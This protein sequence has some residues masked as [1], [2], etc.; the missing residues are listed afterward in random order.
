M[1]KEYSVGFLLMKNSRVIARMYQKAL[2][3]SGLTTPQSGIILVL[4]EAGEL[5]QSKISE[6]LNLDKANASIMLKRMGE[7][8][9]VKS[10]T[11]AKDHRKVIFSLTPKGKKM[12]SAIAAADREIT[13]E[14]VDAIGPELAEKA[15]KILQKMHEAKHLR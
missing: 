13:E 4:N 15:Q 8:G 14:I 7:D 10:R 1:S 5:C 9:M 2:M 3:T 12:V 11:D 6:A